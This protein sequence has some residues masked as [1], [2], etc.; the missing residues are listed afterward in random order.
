MDKTTAEAI[1]DVYAFTRNVLSAVILDLAH[2]GAEDRAEAIL[3]LVDELNEKSLSSKG[4]AVAA[5]QLSTVLAA[6]RA[7]KPR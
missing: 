1:G 6:L 7:S 3:R 4:R 5:D 2:Y